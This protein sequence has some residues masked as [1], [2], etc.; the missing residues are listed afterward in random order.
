[1]RQ[2]AGSVRKSPATTKV[3]EEGKDKKVLRASEGHRAH[4]GAHTGAGGD[5]L[6]ETTAGREPVQEPGEE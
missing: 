1:M 4:R 5:A 3:R 2:Q 6:K